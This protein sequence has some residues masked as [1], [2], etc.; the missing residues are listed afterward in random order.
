MQSGE[1]IEFLLKFGPA[2]AAGMMHLD[3]VAVDP[4]LWESLASF[5]VRL[6]PP[7]KIGG[8]LVPFEVV[9]QRL[10]DGSAEIT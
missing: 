3:Y 7:A 8:F 6:F 4:F 9:L 2:S 1:R 5:A 10:V